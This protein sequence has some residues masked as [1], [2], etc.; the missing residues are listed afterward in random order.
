MTAHRTRQR[1]GFVLLPVILAMT[2][3][4]A[5]A[6]LLNRDNGLNA[7]MV[8]DQRDTDRARYAAE[9]GLQALNADI[10]THSCVGWY[11]GLLSP[12]TN[13]NFGGASYSAYAWPNWGNSTSLTS[14]GSYNGSSATL[15]R[16]NVIAY[17]TTSKT[18][19][20][21]PN[22]AAGIDTY[23]DIGNKNDGSFN[24][25]WVSPG[26]DLTL[27]KFDLSAFPAGSVPLAAT[28]SLYRT[29]GAT[30]S[31]TLSM[32]RLRSNWVEGTGANSPQDGVNWSTSD[33]STPWTPGGDFHPVAVSSIPYVSGT[34]F[35]DA[36]DVTDLVMAWLS[37]RYPNQ[38]LLI[39][40]SAGIGSMKYVSSDYSNAS[41]RPK[42]AI[43]YLVPCGAS[44]PADVSGG[45][46]VTLG[47]V[48]DSFMDSAAPNRNFG[49][50]TRL[51]LNYTGSTQMRPLLIFD[52]SGIAPGTLIQSAK[53]RLNVSLI[54][55]KSGNPKSISAYA[56]TES[57]V[58]G[59]K[60]GTGTANGVTWDKRNTSNNWVTAG[61]TYRSP[62]VALAVEEASG[63]SPPPGS[64]STGWLSWDVTALVQEWVD[65]VTP[66]NGVLLISTLTDNIFMDSKE[67]ATAANRPQ[68]VIGW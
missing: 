46:A 9:A 41:Q 22:A 49:A 53:L 58:E 16:N 64:F 21:Q 17:Q 26:Y 44:G 29:G 68:L 50:T 27:L 11:P 31:G 35:W 10:Q 7:E 56:L 3:I 42:L 23:I 13:S 60:T 51:Q 24:T 37:G 40:G 36:F 67:F 18:Y 6:F 47:P 4:A 57:W 15:N 66:N 61:S 5:I 55:S 1:A 30:G 2:L 54:A 8:S 39:S 62:A 32:Q 20:L 65:G 28:L 34:N 38:G 52:T 19:T 45:G 63:T 12:K 25:M 59:N 43:S 48:A 33:G 14:T